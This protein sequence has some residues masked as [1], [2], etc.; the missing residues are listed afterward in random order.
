MQIPSW[1]VLHL[2]SVQD[3]KNACCSCTAFIYESNKPNILHNGNP[4]YRELGGSYRRQYQEHAQ[5]PPETI[6]LFLVPDIIQCN[7]TP[8]NRRCAETEDRETC[9]AGFLDTAEVSDPL[10]NVQELDR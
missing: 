2:K 4:R 3:N 9:C 10:R 5:Q 8:T 1:P 7:R 6:L